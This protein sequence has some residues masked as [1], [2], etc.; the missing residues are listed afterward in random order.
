MAPATKTEMVDWWGYCLSEL[1]SIE[2]WERLAIVSKEPVPSRMIWRGQCL[3]DMM[4]FFDA[5]E[6]NRVAHERL[7]MQARAGSAKGRAK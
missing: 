6:I 1:A 4:E 3:R 2:A 7:I 5:I